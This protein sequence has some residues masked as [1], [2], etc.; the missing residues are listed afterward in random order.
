MSHQFS[1]ISTD[2]IGAFFAGQS[3]TAS[4]PPW[5]LDELPEYADSRLWAIPNIRVPIYWESTGAPS[6][7]KDSQTLELES[8]LYEC[9]RLLNATMS[10]YALDQRV[11]Y[12]RGIVQ[13]L[14]GYLERQR[15]EDD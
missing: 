14:N 8:L 10:Q 1:P 11:D 15:H 9:T 6:A 2:K 3:Q 13:L 4:T 5:I 12:L 7:E